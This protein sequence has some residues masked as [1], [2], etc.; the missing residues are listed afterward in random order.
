MTNRRIA[1]HLGILLTLITI[2]VA[3][4]WFFHG[5]LGV[6]H[7]IESLKDSDWRKRYQTIAQLKKIGP[8]AKPA[9]AELLTL[10]KQGAHRSAAAPL[11]PIWRRPSSGPWPSSPSA[12]SSAK[13]RSRGVASCP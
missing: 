12:P 11:T 7:L 5:P 13:N 2:G 3:M 8:A 1:F 10:A 9:V 4:Y 6:P